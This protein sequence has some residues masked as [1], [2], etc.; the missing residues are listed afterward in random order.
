MFILD[1]VFLT[2]KFYEDY[3]ACTEIERKPTRPH[4]CA[5]LLVNGNLCCIPFRSNIKHEYAIWT[6]KEHKCG[7]DF[8]KTVAIIDERK[9][10]D[11]SKRAYLRPNE[12]AIFK[13]VTDRDI[14]AA[15][16]RYLKQYR[17]AKAAPQVAHNKILL[18]YSCIQ[19]FEKYFGV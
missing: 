14:E 7:L 2:D 19:Y 9:Y 15:L 3:A 8:S 17:R 4:L 5:A 11:R 18:K 13:T 16:K 6:D 10:I 1:L 12:Y